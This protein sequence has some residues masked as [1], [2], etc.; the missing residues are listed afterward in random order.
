MKARL[1][2][3]LGFVVALMVPA[4]GYAHPLVDEARHSYE[5]ASLPEAIATLDRALAGND[6]SLTDYIAALELRVLVHLADGSADALD[7]DLRFLAAIAGDRTLSPEIPPETRARY[8]QIRASQG[9]PLAAQA[10]LTPMSDGA[11][12][13]VDAL[14]VPVGLNVTVKIH[15]QVNDEDWQAPILNR[16]ARVHAEMGSQIAY[17]VELIGPG[18]AVLASSGS[19]HEP[20]VAQLN[21]ALNPAEHRRDDGAPIWPYLVGAGVVGAA[22]IT[23]AVVLLA[24]GK[25]SSGGTQVSAP[26]VF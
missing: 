5:Q 17:F 26:M 2:L 13:Q 12:I 22:A 9:G 14:H 24:G 16:T 1:L 25:D 20:I 19:E 3:S 21:R 11:T 10:H 6:L 23:V 4:T 15:V 18:G 8:E 7:N